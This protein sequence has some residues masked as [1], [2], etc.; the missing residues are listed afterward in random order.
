MKIIPKI[1]AQTPKALNIALKSISSVSSSFFLVHSSS[2]ILFVNYV[3]M[4]THILERLGFNKPKVKRIQRRKKWMR[5]NHTVI[6]A[7]FTFCAQKSWSPDR[8]I[9]I[10]YL[11]FFRCF[12]KKTRSSEEILFSVLNSFIWHFLKILPVRMQFKNMETKKVL[13]SL[14]MMVWCISYTRALLSRAS[15]RK[16]WEVIVSFYVYLFFSLQHQHTMDLECKK[17]IQV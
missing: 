12:C 5:Y 15:A 3:D 4:H 16:N 7:F 6:F 1:N 14:K 9:S 17:R 11:W 2:D 10:P 8:F 13:I